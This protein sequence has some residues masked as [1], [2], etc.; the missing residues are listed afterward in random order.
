MRTSTNLKGSTVPL[1]REV[2]Y[3]EERSKMVVM[4][5]GRLGDNV[6]KRGPQLHRLLK[7]DWIGQKVLEI[8]TGNGVIAG[9]L[10]IAVEGIWSYIGTELAPTFRKSAQAMF[11]LHTVPTDVLEIPGE[12]YTRI[13][14]LDSLE[15]VRPEH[16]EAGYERIAKV[17]A[18]DA[19]LFIHLS[20]SPSAHDKE[21]DHPF[22]L[23]DL[24][25][26]EGV[27]FRL[28]NYE[29]YVCQ[30]PKALLDYAFVVMQK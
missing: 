12:G 26:L 19:L 5:D 6:W 25:R 27:G 18:K 14:A 21:F 16:R 9:A 24:V 2:A 15:H 4:E 28:V 13:L 20:Y 17:A 10:Q 30:H 1:A 7:Y 8:G 11:H 22:G 29:R 23:F 3:W